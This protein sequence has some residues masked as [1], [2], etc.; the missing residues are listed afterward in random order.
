MTMKIFRALG[1]LLLLTGLGCKDAAV[2]QFTEAALTSP[3]TSPESV[4]PALT[5]DP[6]SGDLL[7]S[8]V[9]GDSAGWS[10]FFARSRDQGASWSAPTV[11]VTGDQEIHPQGE[12]SPR[13]VAAT[14]GRVALSWVRR[15][16]VPD[17]RWPGTNV[18]LARS[19]DGGET[20]STP[21]TLNDDT[22]GAAAGHQF[23]GAAW[24]GD[25]GLVVSWLD[26]REGATLAIHQGQPSPTAADVTDEPDA[27]IYRAT[28]PDF[29]QTWGSSNQ[30]MWGQVCP[31]CR[32]NLARGPGGEVVTAW[33][34]HYPGN[35]RDVVT[36][37]LTDAPREPS[38]VHQDNWVYPGCPYTGPGV[39]VGNDGVRHFVWYMGKEGKAGV[40]Y[41]RLA[42]TAVETD[43]ALPL[44]RARTLPS[45]HTTVT[46]LS[47]GRALAAYDMTEAGNRAI[48]VSL[49]GPDRTIQQHHVFTGSEGG[50]YPQVVASGEGRAVV[51]W[52]GKEG[53]RRTVRLA[54][55]TF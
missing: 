39:S 19:L 35:I 8:W 55:I 52:T 32:V 20:W 23:H 34:K 37:T 21:I 9:G 16:P 12:S 33:R 46:A 17:R 42:G 31:C 4:D 47:G 41:Q 14:G 43:S 48:A 11:V 3:A 5:V 7:L 29:G 1:G 6:S 45:A 54:A 51:S 2:V 44:I 53:E 22:A 25:S 36:A 49:I 27:V 28:S 24:S 30:L 18:R 13:L 15:V 26:E 40:Y 10:L 38:R 50:Q